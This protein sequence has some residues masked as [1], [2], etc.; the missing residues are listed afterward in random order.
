MCKG[1][2]RM[3]A[4]GIKVAPMRQYIGNAPRD[5]HR[6]VARA[7]GWL[8]YERTAMSKDG[9]VTLKLC[10]TKP[11]AHKANFHLG[12]NVPA[13]RLGRGHEVTLLLRLLPG[14]YRWV[15]EVMKSKHFA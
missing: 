6:V 2:T 5:A 13:Q 11:L 8:L 1:S 7:A 9:W 3:A 15:E 14:T 10:S 12:W 4:K